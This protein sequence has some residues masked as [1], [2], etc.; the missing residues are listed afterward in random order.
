[1]KKMRNFLTFAVTT[2]LLLTAVSCDN[3]IDG[4]IS[5][6]EKFINKW[7]GKAGSDNPLSEDDKKELR[8][9]LIDLGKH[10]LDIEK[11]P[12]L[13]KDMTPEQEKKLQELGMEAAFIGLKAQY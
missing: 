11:N 8:N 10:R 12:D 1:M 9:D 13:L 6:Y 4:A 2:F 5:D 7:E 3:K